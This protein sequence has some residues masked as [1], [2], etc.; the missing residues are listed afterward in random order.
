M[1]AVKKKQLV[2]L[3]L[4]LLIVLQL[5]AQIPH[6][7]SRP[8]PIGAEKSSKLRSAVDFFV[9]MPSL[10]TDSALYIDDLPGN[11]V[12]GLRFAHT[13]F[14]NLSPENSGIVFNAEDGSRIWK[15]GIRSNGAFSLN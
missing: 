9:E 7:S 5:H 8:L 10:D 2:L 13:F 14:T 6:G 4:F 15:V 1:A 3:P 11:R 12:G